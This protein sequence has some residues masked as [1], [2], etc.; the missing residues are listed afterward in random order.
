MSIDAEKKAYERMY[1]KYFIEDYGIQGQL[2]D[3]ERPDFKFIN[4]DGTIIDIE[5]TRAFQPK[6]D[7]SKYYPSQIESQ[8]NLIKELTKQHFLEK[9]K[10]PLTVIMTFDKEIICSKK[11][12]ITLSKNLSDLI[13][14]YIKTKDL[15][16]D[17]IISIHN[18]ENIP[19]GIY[20]IGIVYNPD[21]LK[22]TWNGGRAQ[23]LPKLNY[24]RQIW[25]IC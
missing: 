18:D 9:Y 24:Y 2:I 21:V 11:E 15:S 4:S 25:T 6:P 13:Y 20:Y 17:F 5:V 23:F 8:F 19:S 12:T 14:N 3:D 10:I 22:T 16:S 7:N 1:L